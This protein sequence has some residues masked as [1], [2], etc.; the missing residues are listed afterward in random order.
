MR[1]D[2]WGQHRFTGRH[3]CERIELSPGGGIGIRA[4]LRTMFRKDWRFESSPGHQ[5]ILMESPSTQED[6]QEQEEQYFETYEIKQTDLEILSQGIDM[7]AESGLFEE[8]IFDDI[9]CIT[10]DAKHFYVFTKGEHATNERFN[11]EEIPSPSK[12]GFKIFKI[13]HSGVVGKTREDY[14]VAS[15]CF[16]WEEVETTAVNARKFLNPGF[17]FGENPH[18]KEILDAI[19]MPPEEPYAKI[20]HGRFNYLTDCIFH[21]AGHIEHY[22]LE[23]WQ[24]GEET[25]VNFSSAEQEEKF[26]STVRKTKLLPE[27]AVDLIFTGFNQADITGMYA[28]LIDSE[29]AKNYDARVFDNGNRDFQKMLVDIGG[30]SPNQETIQFFQRFLDE[31]HGK[32]IV[33]VKILEEQFPDFQER[34]RFV[35][36]VLEH[37]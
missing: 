13:A 20:H 1:L 12:T 4:W 22:V 33:L 23:R 16:I 5:R 27:W 31:H 25:V 19:K 11:V 21:E 30:E 18:P 14:K 3:F 24:A 6:T 26:I 35:R 8:G 32:G 10:F 37:R 36:S 28:V 15:S 9:R 29:A 34:K 17:L 2:V 7:A